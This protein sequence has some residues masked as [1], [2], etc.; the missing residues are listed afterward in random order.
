M[1]NDLFDNK[2]LKKSS[3][4]R[5]FLYAGPVLPFE[6]E[7]AA[8]K[9]ADADE[10][11]ETFITQAPSN[12][13]SQD[14]RQQFQALQLQTGGWNARFIYTLRLPTVTG[15]QYL[16]KY[17]ALNF[18]VEDFEQLAVH[19]A[20][21]VIFEM[22]LPRDQKT[23]PEV[24]SPSNDPDRPVFMIRGIMLEVASDPR[25][26]LPKAEVDQLL[27]L[28]TLITCSTLPCDDNLP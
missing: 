5:K 11:D 25:I 13:F 16:E 28:R 23:L 10:I 9:A 1:Q 2:S 20:Q 8:L 18:L 17:E 21:I 6:L 26:Q 12:L 7:G 19:W 4:W 27:L 15:Q 3:D 22:K 24:F 14:I